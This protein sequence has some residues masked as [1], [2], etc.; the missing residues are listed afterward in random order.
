MNFCKVIILSTLLV[1]VGFPSNGK[2][3]QSYEDEWKKEQRESGGKLLKFLFGDSDEEDED[4]E[5]NSDPANN[6]GI[7][8]E[9]T[10]VKQTDNPSDPSEDEN[11]NSVDDTVIETEKVE[12]SP[13]PSPVIVESVPETPEVQVV[14]GQERDGLAP[15]PGFTEEV[16]KKIENSP[17]KEPENTTP[18]DSIVVEGLSTAP[19]SEKANPENVGNQED[20]Q[21][22]PKE[23]PNIT[24]TKTESELERLDRENPVVAVVEGDEIYWQDITQAAKKLP[25]QYQGQL[26]TMFPILL[27]RA[28][29][30][31]LLAHAGAD[32]DM[33]EKEDVKRKLAIAEEKIIRDAYLEQQ[34]NEMITEA[35][36]RDRYFALLRENIV[37]AEI[38]ARHILVETRNEALAL[39]IALDNGAEFHLLAKKFSKGP[40]AEKGGDLGWF[41]QKDMD[42]EF[43][44]AA[45]SLV[46][47]SYTK[48]PVAT[49]FGWHVIKLEDRRD[50]KQ[51]TFESMRSEI[52]EQVSR[53]LVAHMVRDL[54]KD[55]DISVFPAN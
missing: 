33:D 40:S 31:K 11:I 45:F 48:A 27:D 47:G 30:L 9:V 25:E 2:A 53:E 3:Q 10:P 29:D 4:P 37:N 20:T 14:P 50:V 13:V 8:E 38:R 5:N 43:A 17:K 36:L 23:T 39:I 7:E 44:S 19:I 52:K 16:E 18:E 46:P 32:A 41:K 26:E 55:A 12:S 15:P 49:D 24:L 22:A 6:P 54:R 21:T 35:M 51:P 42:P 1:A 34:L 28:I